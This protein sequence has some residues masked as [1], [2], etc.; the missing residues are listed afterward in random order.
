MLTLAGIELVILFAVSPDILRLV[1]LYT[2]LHL[3]SPVQDHL[4]DAICHVDYSMKRANVRV[5][6][7]VHEM[8]NSIDYQNEEWVA[9]TH[10][11]LNLGAVQRSDP[12]GD[13]RL[14]PQHLVN[15]LCVATQGSWYL[16][17]KLLL[18][19][20]QDSCWSAKFW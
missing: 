4:L 2:Q 13:W 20:L 12:Y 16:T 11:L 18:Q 8:G 6:C 9:C 5:L 14:F 19:L 15:L 17:R 7:M 1:L 10:H 3:D